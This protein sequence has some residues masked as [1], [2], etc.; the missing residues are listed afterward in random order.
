MGD[1]DSKPPPQASGLSRWTP[2]LPTTIMSM[3]NP[4]GSDESDKS[5]AESNTASHQSNK[6]KSI[7]ASIL[8]NSSSTEPESS[9]KDDSIFFAE[10]DTRSTSDEGSR[11]G[12][13]FDGLGR[14]RSVR[15]NKRKT[16][17]S[18]CHPPPA[19]TTRQRMHRRPR[20]LI[21]LHKLSPPARPRPAFEVIPSTN[22]SV[23]L[24]KAIT[25]VFKT[26]HGLCPNDL[27]VLRAEKY[28]EDKSDEDQEASDI[29]ALICKGRKEDG[30]VQGK[31]KICLPGGHEWEAYP[32]LKGGYEFFS[33]DEHGLGLTVRW[34]PKKNKDC[35]RT[36]ESDKRT[37]SKFNFS[38]ISP[39]SRRH[40]VIATLD[41]TGLDIYDTYKIP[42]PSAATP[43]STPQLGSPVLAD[44]MDDETGGREEYETD[45]RLRQIIIMTG[46][47]VTFKEGWSPSFKYDDKDKD[48]NSIQRSPSLQ[49]S[50]AK[51][52]TFGSPVSTPP[53][54]P[55]PVPLE[56]RN[57]FMGV[58][59]GILRRGSLL[60]RGNRTS[61]A[62][63]PESKDSEQE[64]AKKT[65]RARAD[66]A[67][68]V[69][70][71]R[72]ASNRAKNRQ[73]TWRPDLVSD[74]QEASNE[75]TPRSPRSPS[76]PS[77]SAAALWNTSPS[78]T[79][80][81]RESIARPILPP[82]HT[83][84]DSLDSEVEQDSFAP[85]PRSTAGKP[86]DPEKRESSTTT[87]TNSSRD[88]PRKALQPSPKPKKKKGGWRRLL[89]GSGH[90]I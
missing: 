20:S 69:L 70:V 51:S 46:I 7:F 89:C 62:S 64:V 53:G 40:P 29:I 35:N 76:A 18:I 56:K 79:P 28:S 73:A 65:G 8:P 74:M 45:D 25:K 9:D 21:Q 60:G 68:T 32:I 67:S 41:K 6:N 83:S 16:C 84:G 86:L 24:T 39:N 19:S 26:K 87:T 90:D 43:L 33:T 50:P 38:T 82:A 34:V 66:S 5:N 4:F 58:G 52:A 15:R 59:S 49:Y 10:P 14:K 47:W 72:A 13:V 85:I 63:V 11:E 55:S 17:Y 81:R 71:H 54:S 31:A 22:F 42:D 1:T 36:D 23:R 3:F 2:S 75:N 88:A 80:G 37:R 78:P 44:A 30:A 12:S 48:T 57:S 27:V 77:P 61:S